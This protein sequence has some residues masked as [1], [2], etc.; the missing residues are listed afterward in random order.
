MACDQRSFQSKQERSAGQDKLPQ[1]AQK[2]ARADMRP[3]FPYPYLA[4]N[5]QFAAFYLKAFNGDG[6]FAGGRF[7]Q[8]IL[9]RV[10]LCHWSTYAAQ[11]IALYFDHLLVR[12]GAME[13]GRTLPREFEAVYF[14]EMR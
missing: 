9:Q 7:E 4:D 12:G 14:E 5:H 3:G 10:A 6:E 2:V 8:G 11:K 13:A 1:D